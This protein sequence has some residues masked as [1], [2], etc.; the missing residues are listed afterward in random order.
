M[1]IR[2]HPVLLID[3]SQDTQ[4]DLISAFLVLQA[5]YRNNFSLCLFGD[6]MQRIYADGKE[7]LEDDVPEDWETPALVVNYR[8]PNRVV[9][10]LNQIRSKADGVRQ[11]PR[12]DAQEGDVR[13]FLVNDGDEINKLEVESKAAKMMAEVTSDDEWMNQQTIKVL[14]LEHQMAARRGGFDHFFEPLYSIP[15]FKTGLLDGTLNG[16]AFFTQQVLPLVQAMKSGDK[17]AVARVVKEHSPILSPKELSDSKNS[18][19]FNP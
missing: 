13:L 3:E 2:K 5:K 19:G 8:C 10:L 14:T 11:V 18:S 6:T 9:T 4:K 7:G 12:P 1:L 15:R 16:I 17:F